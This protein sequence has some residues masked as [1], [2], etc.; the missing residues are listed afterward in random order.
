MLPGRDARIG[1]ERIDGRGARSTHSAQIVKVSS[2]VAD[3]VDSGNGPPRARGGV[4]R[5][6]RLDKPGA[7][8]APLRSAFALAQL[9]LPGPGR[10]L[11]LTPA[12][13][14]H[15]FDE[16][17]LAREAHELTSGFATP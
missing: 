5:P 14:E 6:T 2:V 17:R 8:F 3:D 7:G 9:R 12:R 15:R 13:T 11:S 1:R 10:L 16:E 4:A